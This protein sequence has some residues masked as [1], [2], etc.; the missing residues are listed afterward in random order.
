[1][2]SIA[3]GN[4]PSYNDATTNRAVRA[5]LI[6]ENQVLGDKVFIPEW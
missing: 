1:M 4:Q 6:Y 2:E 5:R 3:V